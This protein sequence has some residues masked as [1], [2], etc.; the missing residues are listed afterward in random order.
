MKLKIR[1][2]VRADPDYCFIETDLSGAEAWIVA[3]LSDDKAMQHELSEGDL[4]KY[5]ASFIFSKPY[6]DISD[7]E[8]YVGKKA[9]HS[10]NY[11]TSPNMLAI[12]INKEGLISVSI[13]QAKT[14][15]N[16]WHAAFNVRLWWSDIESQL[17]RNRTIITSY[18]RKRVFHGRWCD[19]MLKA[20]TAYE[21]QST[22]A[23]HMYGALCPEVGIEGGLLHL[24]KKILVKYKEI[25]LIQTA[26]D[27]AVLH[28]PKVIANEILDLTVS[29]L[30]RPLVVRGQEFTIPVDSKIYPERWYGESIK[31]F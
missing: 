21:P 17:N 22:V 12:S 19:D 5:A 30:K 16:R 15:Y 11:R 1:S 3:Y 24:H 28:C 20:A 8:R 31:R 7:N 29:C 4:H 10:L 27:S 14:Y 18:R 13:A 25:Q 2:M 23:D 9:N 26:H 6:S